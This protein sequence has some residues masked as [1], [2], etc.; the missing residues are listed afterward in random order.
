MALVLVCPRL[1]SHYPQGKNGA[2]FY[3]QLKPSRWAEYGGD[4]ALQIP[5]TWEMLQLHGK[6]L[7]LSVWDAWTGRAVTFLD[8]CYKL[9]STG[10]CD[11]ATG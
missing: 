2:S 8:I 5:V 4:N 1:Q 10:A 11:L 7:N 9:R 3:A 6:V